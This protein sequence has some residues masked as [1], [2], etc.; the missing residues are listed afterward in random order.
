[1]YHN[2]TVQWKKRTRLTNFTD[3]RFFSYYKIQV[4]KIEIIMCEENL[5]MISFEK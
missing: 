1:M 2:F 5:E 4:H 3:K